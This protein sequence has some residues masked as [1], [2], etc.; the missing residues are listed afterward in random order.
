MWCLCCLFL[1]FSLFD[2]VATLWLLDAG[3]T[4]LNPVMSFLLRQG[5]PVFLI[6]KLTMTVAALPILLICRN[7]Y[8]FGTKL[9]VS[10]LL[11]MF[12]A[13]YATLN[14]YQFVLFFLV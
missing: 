10:A 2:A 7:F 9:R 1:T 13:L 5:A 3:C 8:L 11:P 6:G 14:V 12:V 4:E